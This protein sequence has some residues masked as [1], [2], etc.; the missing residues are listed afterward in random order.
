MKTETYQFA[1]AQNE[2]LQKCVI[3]AQKQSMQ[4]HEVS[5]LHAEALLKNGK[6]IFV[7]LAGNFFKIEGI[8]NLNDY[9]PTTLFYID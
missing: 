2:A 7:C 8:E 1:N 6:H 5:R 4:Y 9:L 3:E